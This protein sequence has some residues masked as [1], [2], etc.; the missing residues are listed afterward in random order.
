MHITQGFWLFHLSHNLA[1]E[2]LSASAATRGDLL[3]PAGKTENFQE[4][5]W[6]SLVR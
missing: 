5:V 2:W 3:R 1:A 4:N 6:L